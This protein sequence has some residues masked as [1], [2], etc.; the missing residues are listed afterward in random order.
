MLEKSTIVLTSNDQIHAAAYF[1]WDE[2]SVYYLMSGSVPRIS[3]FPITNFA[4][5]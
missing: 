5:I 3:K 2:E 4:I 1:V